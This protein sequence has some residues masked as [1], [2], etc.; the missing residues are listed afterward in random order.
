[1]GEANL[2][3]FT[4]ETDKRSFTKGI[5]AL[6]FR[7]YQVNCRCWINE[8]LFREYSACHQIFLF[9]TWNGF[10]TLIAVE[11]W[12]IWS[13]AQML[14]LLKVHK[15]KSIK[16]CQF[17]WKVILWKRKLV[18]FVEALSSEKEINGEG[19]VLKPRD[20]LKQPCVFNLSPLALSTLFSQMLQKIIPLCFFPGFLEMT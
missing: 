20:T 3:S 7:V 2:S 19:E 14:Q 17:I 1:M 18:C 9:V 16:W 5:Y 8:H 15:Q 4:S 12:F 13:I 6:N 11:N 10:A